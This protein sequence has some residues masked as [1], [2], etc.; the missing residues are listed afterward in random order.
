MCFAW[1]PH[2]QRGRAMVYARLTAG[3]RRCFQ[4]PVLVMAL[5]VGLC[6]ASSADAITLFVQVET[7][8][9]VGVG[10]GGVQVTLRTDSD[11][12]LGGTNITFNWDMAGIRVESASSPLSSSASEATGILVPAGALA[13]H[14]RS[15]VSVC[16]PLTWAP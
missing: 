8:Q 2:R 6:H 4:A 12:Q 7:L 11:L 9:P 16:G 15:S 14:T 3:G 10:A 5:G 13:A 1:W